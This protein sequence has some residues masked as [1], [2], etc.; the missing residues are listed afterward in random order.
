M[1][2]LWSLTSLSVPVEVLGVYSVLLIFIYTKLRVCIGGVDVT[3]FSR[4]ALW[5]RMALCADSEPSRT[6]RARA[7]V[8]FNDEIWGLS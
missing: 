3:P 7:P 6:P 8:D 1:P 4:S 2:A 5:R